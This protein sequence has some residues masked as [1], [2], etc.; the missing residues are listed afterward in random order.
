M[1][2][3]IA[4]AAANEGLTITPQD[5][6]IP[7]PGLA[8][9]RRRRVAR[10]QRVGEASEAQANPA[11]LPNVTVLDCVDCATPAAVVPLILRLDPKIATGYSSGADLSGQPPRRIAPRTRSATMD[12]EQHIA[13]IPQNSPLSNRSVRPTAWLQAAPEERAAVLGILAELLEDQ[14]DLGTRRWL[15]FIM[16]LSTAVHHLAMMAHRRLISQILATDT[17]P[18]LT[19]AGRR[20]DHAETGQHRVA[21]RSL[22]CAVLATHLAALTLARTRIENSTKATLWLA[23]ALPTRIPPIRPAPTSSPSCRAR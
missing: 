21:G 22:R 11:V 17:S 3:S 10:V 19:T 16:P 7:D 18:R 14:T 15:P 20:G 4:M 13:A 1:A 23:D 5:L 6:R 12:M 9:G 2:I 8:D